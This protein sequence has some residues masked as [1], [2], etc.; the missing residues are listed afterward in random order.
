MPKPRSGQEENR[1]RY[2][3][4]RKA[5][6][7]TAISEIQVRASLR[8]PADKA[9]AELDKMVGAYESRTTTINTLLVAEADLNELQGEYDKL[10]EVTATQPAG[11]EKAGE[12]D[13]ARRKRKDLITELLNTNVDV[14][15]VEDML[16]LGR[17]NDV[18]IKEMQKLYEEHPDLDSIPDRSDQ[19]VRSVCRSQG[20]ARRPGGPDA[21]PARL[22]ACSSSASWPGAT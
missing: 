8:L 4:A 6:M 2:M 16:A 11:E 10:D 12:V 3:A 21:T 9:K 19:G 15:V 1:E 14:R 18:R 7:D 20:N 17:K 13:E 22:P 5:L